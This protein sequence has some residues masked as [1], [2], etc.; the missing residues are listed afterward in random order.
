MDEAI[1]IMR[2]VWSQSPASFHGKHYAFDGIKVLPQPAQR[3]PIW[4]GGTSAAA[5]TGRW[6]AA[7]ATRR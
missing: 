6:P 5:A 3:I 2:L 4:I 7:T 1:E